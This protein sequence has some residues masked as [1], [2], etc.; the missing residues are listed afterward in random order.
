MRFRAFSRLLASAFALVLTTGLFSTVN[1][2]T[3]AGQLVGTWKILR[4][5]N[6]DA[7]GTVARPYGDHPQGFF[8]YDATGHLGLQLMATPAL[9]PFASGNDKTGTDAEVRAAYNA[10]VAYF[11]TYRVD[12]QNH[13]VTHIVEGALQ[14]SY[15]GSE[16]PRHFTLEG[17]LLTIAGQT[18]D[19]GR[20][21]R[22]LQRVR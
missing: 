3:L 13:I 12:E 11:G 1:A 5:E 7:H 6:Y 18:P 22:E 2:Q 15:T 16:Q 20:Y 14:P 19:G 10:Y 21:L 17:D 9:K 4:Y 8:M